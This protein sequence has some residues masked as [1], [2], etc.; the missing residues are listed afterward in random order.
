MRWFYL[1]FLSVGPL[2]G[3]PP[4]GSGAAHMGPSALTPL[5]PLLHD[6]RGA[7]RTRTWSQDGDR[8]DRGGQVG[9]RGSTKEK[10]SFFPGLA[11]LLL[12]LE[13]SRNSDFLINKLIQGEG[14]LHL[15]WVSLL[16]F[17]MESLEMP[18]HGGE[19]ER[20]YFSGFH[21]K[22]TH[23]PQRQA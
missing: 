22:I 12:C 17:N 3:A 8:G 19:A 13:S 9:L 4:S 1:H 5:K 23:M 2:G 11:G 21:E 20:K 7:R 16:L 6:G 15:N 18:L 10:L 14:C